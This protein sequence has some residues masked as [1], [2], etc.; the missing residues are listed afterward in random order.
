[1]EE[2]PIPLVAWESAYQ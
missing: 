1:M 2:V